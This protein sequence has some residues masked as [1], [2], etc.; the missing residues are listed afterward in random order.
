[1]TLDRISESLRND[2]TI[3]KLLQGE[4]LSIQELLSLKKWLD[5]RVTTY[6]LDNQKE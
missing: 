4:T 2:S 6:L 5:N 3:E 1:M